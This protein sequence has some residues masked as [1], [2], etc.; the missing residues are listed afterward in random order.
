M[1]YEESRKLV[2]SII[3]VSLFLI[4]MTCFVYLPKQENLLSS[5]AFIQNQKSFYL[6]DLSQ[7]I[8]LNDAIPVP[9]EVGMQYQPY[10]FKVVNS[11]NSEINY[12][13]IFRNNDSKMNIKQEDLLSNQYLRISLNNNEGLLVNPVSL[14]ENGVIYTTTIRA[15]EEEVFELRMWLDWNSDNN[16]MD[17]IFVGKI[18][19][20]RFD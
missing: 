17:K 13:I 19:V 12:R 4:F 16:A 20:D 11:S 10:R 8:L 3:L 14:S 6:K 1:K 5:L 18:E 2:L 9:D 15:H 7:G